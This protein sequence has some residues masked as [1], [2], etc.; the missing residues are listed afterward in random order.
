[1][2]ENDLDTPE[3]QLGQA[4]TDAE[5]NLGGDN[6]LEAA[7]EYLNNVLGK[8]LASVCISRKLIAL[9]SLDHFSGC[10]LAPKSSG[11]SPPD[12]I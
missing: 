1:M 9:E 7:R 10:A 3:E 12:F 6:Q 2:G 4:L 5:S 11:H 8:L